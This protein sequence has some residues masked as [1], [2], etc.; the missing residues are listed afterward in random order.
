MPHEVIW[1]MAAI[2]DIEAHFDYLTE[3]VSSGMQLISA[4][5]F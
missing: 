4:S 3:H 2:E 5:V 1:S